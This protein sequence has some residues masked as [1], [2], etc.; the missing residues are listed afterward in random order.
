MN[1]GNPAIET[2]TVEPYP[3]RW[4]AL[5]VLLAAMFINM[6]DI[7]IVNIGLPDMQR[8]LQATDQQL[9]WVMELYIITF[10]LSLLPFARF[11][12]IVG[13]KRMFLAGL[14]SFTLTSGLCGAAQTASLLILAR[15]AQGIS[16]AMMASQ[17]MA[18]AQ[19]MFAPRE[20]G[21]VFPLFAIVGGLSGIAGPLVSGLLLHANYFDLGWR[22]LFLINL[23]FG[24]V[25]LV[26]AQVL[27]PPCP[28]HGG[29]RNDWLGMTLAALIVVA[30]LYPLIEGRVHGWPAWSFVTLLAV[31]PMVSAFVAWERR[32]ARREESALI[33]AY[34]LANRDYVAGCAA[35]MVFFSALQGF[36]F[37]FALYLQ[38]GIGF[39]PLQT[40]LATV[41]FPIGIMLASVIGARIVPLK[42]KV[43]GGALVLTATFLITAVMIRMLPAKELGTLAFSLPMLAGG[44]A[45][46]LC[47]GSLFQGVMRTVPLKDAGAG[48][49]MSQVIQ[50][51]GTGVGIALVSAIF[52]SG[53][54]APHL[55]AGREAAYA[56]AFTHTLIYMVVAYAVVA[57]L[58]LRINFPPPPGPPGRPGGP[59]GPPGG[60][61]RA[62]SG[63]A[64]HLSAGPRGPSGP[65]GPV[66][67]G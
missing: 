49:G 62:G 55:A 25:A 15:A 44:L 11:G 1:A 50:Q 43:V 35:I 23:P 32:R 66:R 61:P 13:R 17:I 45:S 40:G 34:L 7:T 36:F 64:P 9:Q 46:G 2:A 37:V 4:A 28:A 52:F 24:M 33:P 31:V 12:D 51:I 27:V 54:S 16:A 59:F 8:S 3:R 18:I 58:G 56:S 21:R 41:P 57:A 48:S 63:P 39:S 53:I 60:P 67:G 42:P 6:L 22:S 5:Y 65:T 29:L 20:R 26:A 47:I 38:Q 14:A 10:A 19:T 30:L